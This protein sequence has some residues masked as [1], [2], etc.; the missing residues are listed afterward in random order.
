MFSA[1]I[2][3]VVAGGGP[4]NLTCRCSKGIWEGYLICTNQ[5][6]PVTI[7]ST[8]VPGVS[9]SKFRV[10]LMMCRVSVRWGFE[11]FFAS[12]WT[13]TWTSVC[14]LL[15]GEWGRKE[16]GGQTSSHA[17]REPRTETGVRRRNTPT[18]LT[19]NT[20][21]PPSITGGT[22]WVPG[23]DH[24]E[25]GPPLRAQGQAPS[26]L[27]SQMLENWAYFISP[28]GA[29]SRTDMWTSSTSNSS[30]PRATWTP[31]SQTACPVFSC[32]SIGHL[33]SCNI[34]PQVPFMLKEGVELRCLKSSWAIK[35]SNSE[36]WGRNFMCLN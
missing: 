13:Q 24:A 28:L 11:G 26:S 15:S 8:V 12:H 23:S 2:V 30:R 10:M 36:N 20:G 6:L 19:S 17:R 3:P 22:V 4:I 16:Q 32:V 18:C 34:G 27:S 31:G 25:A 5:S 1:H 14:S 35:F 9:A 33:I 7:L 21:T 29:P